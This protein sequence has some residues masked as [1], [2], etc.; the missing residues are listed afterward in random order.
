MWENIREGIIWPS[1]TSDSLHY[2]HKGNDS[3]SFRCSVPYEVSR[4]HSHQELVFNPVKSL[5]MR[6]KKNIFLQEKSRRDSTLF[7]K[8]K[9]SPKEMFK[10]IHCGGF[11]REIDTYMCFNY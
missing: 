1:G 11:D 5:Q 4:H 7:Q 8:F 9:I 3:D 2:E 10:L 6:V